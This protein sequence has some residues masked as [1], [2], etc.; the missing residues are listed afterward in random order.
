MQ[1][2]KGA[3]I[4]YYYRGIFPEMTFPDIYSVRQ[5]ETD[6]KNLSHRT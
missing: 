2:L 3:T 4:L 5:G 6:R 1:T